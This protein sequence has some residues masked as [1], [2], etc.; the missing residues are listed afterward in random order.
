MKRF[1][2]SHFLLLFCFFSEAQTANESVVNNMG[3][4]FSNASFNIVSSLGEDFIYHDS[5]KSFCGFL[6]PDTLFL[7]TDVAENLN[8]SNSY[9][10][11]PS[12]TSS[13]FILVTNNKNVKL[14]A[15]N[16]LGEQILIN[17]VSIDKF[18][19]PD[20]ALN[21]VYFLV[22]TNQNLNKKFEM[23]IVLCR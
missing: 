8:Y 19:F 13:D 3:S 14:S 9:Y 22:I 23:R 11:Y 16:L 18:K 21:G 4:N 10:V 20:D 15:Y 5:T 7:L 1:L 6:K 2:F 17:Q 12:P